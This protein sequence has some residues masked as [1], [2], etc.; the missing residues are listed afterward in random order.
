MRKKSKTEKC[1]HQKGTLDTTSGKFKHML[2]FNLT[3]LGNCSWKEAAR[4]SD[5]CTAHLL[6]QREL[7]RGENI[8]RAAQF[9]KG[10]RE[11]QLQGNVMKFTI[12]TLPW[13]LFNFVE[14]VG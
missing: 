12:A 2:I 4:T 7:Y 13:S 14:L 9:R 5:N 3:A 6:F 11:S 8:F 10:R 1:T